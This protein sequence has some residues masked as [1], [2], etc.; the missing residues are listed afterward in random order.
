MESMHGPTEFL[1]MTFYFT[2]PY[3]LPEGNDRATW[4]GFSG[5]PSV[6]FDGVIA[7][8][9]GMSSGTMYPTYN[10]DYNTRSS[11]ASPLIINGAYTVLNGQVNA[12]FTIQVD[13]AVTGTNT[14]HVFVCQEGLHGQSNMVVDVLDTEPFTLT[15]VGQTTVATRSFTMD[16]S[17]TESDL[18]IIALVQNDNTKEILQ[19]CQ[20]V[21]DYACTVVV[22]CVPDGVE[23]GWRLQGP[24]GLDMDGTGDL[25]LNLFEAGQFTLT[26]DSVPWWTSPAVNPQTQTVAEDGTITFT[27]SYADGPF[28][29]DTALPLGDPGVG[30]S[31]SLVDVDEDGDLDIHLVNNGSA[32]RLLSNDGHG[33][34]TDIAAGPVADTGAGRSC[35]WAD[36]NGDGHLDMYLVKENEANILLAGDGTGAFTLDPAYGIG[37]TGPGYAAAWF[38]YEHDGDLDL[39]IVQHGAENGLLQN[40]GDPGVGFV[41]FSPVAGTP[42]NNLGN[43][44]SITM[45]DGNLDGIPDL[46]VTNQYNANLYLEDTAIGFNDITG[47]T[48]LGDI[49]NS[50]G[51]AW[52]DF[53][54]DGDMDLYIANEGNPDKFYRCTGSFYYTLDPD[55]VVSDN[56]NGRGVA[57]VDVDND[58]WLDLYVVRNG[59]Q[60][61]MLINDQAGGFFRVP[62]GVDEAGGPGNG[63]VCGDVDGDHRPDVFI[64]REGTADVLLHNMRGVGNH[65]LEIAL[66]ASGANTSALGAMIKVTAGGI[67]QTRLVVS[68]TGY[69]CNAPLRKHFGLGSASTIDQVEIRWPDGEVQTFGGFRAN[70]TLHVVQGENPLSGVGDAVPAVTRLD[71]AYPNPF[72]PRTAFSFSLAHDDHVLLQVFDVRG[73]L[74]RSVVDADLPAGDFRGT[75]VWDGTDNQGRTVTSGTYFYRLT[76]GG[77]FTDTGKMLLLK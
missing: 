72:N 54:N 23:A 24:S 11:I 25:T 31:V 16:A 73:R 14:L 57:W 18:R 38:D 67:T 44:T 28:L 69:M 64:S 30:C 13:L 51:A 63:V 7:E 48:G 55:P 37:D 29:P 20:A 58:G 60:D 22:D 61:L 26:W 32:D 1:P 45:T 33:I 15:T 9:G 4:Y 2:A 47:N 59:Q 68:G 21:P 56:G 5:T 40:I 3:A 76:T 74:V 6:M 53:D 36:F 27:G 70:L 35:A 65:W 77:G 71:G 43:G 34:F 49:N 52:G 12:S 50:T 39:Y 75:Y 46:Y 17:W 62:V 8:V 41:I 19:S 10:A 42:A 66:Q